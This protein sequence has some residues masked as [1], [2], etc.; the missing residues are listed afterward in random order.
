M[1]SAGR[2]TKSAASRKS[3]A[4]AGSAASAFWLRI[5]WRRA[6]DARGSGRPPR[7]DLSRGSGS[8]GPRR[9]SAARR[10]PAD[11]R[12]LSARSR[13]SSGCTNAL[14]FADPVGQASGRLDAR[15][16]T[17]ATDDTIGA[18]TRPSIPGFEV[19]GELGSGGMGV[20]YLARQAGLNRLVAL[21]M[22]LAAEYSRPRRMRGS[23]ARPQRWR[24][25]A[26]T[27]FKSMGAAS[28]R[29]VRI[30]SWSTSMAADWPI[31]FRASHGTRDAKPDWW[32]RSL[33]PPIPPTNGA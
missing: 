13:I 9:E 3:S 14:R 33:A 16:A 8:R 26:S 18:G 5:T 29:A 10:V 4:F 22:I 19:I 11:S 23:A 30:F 31:P 27:L 28:T 7:P 2:R 6:T 32:K 1:G 12:T 25:R 20:V 17:L 15:V 24:L 21:K